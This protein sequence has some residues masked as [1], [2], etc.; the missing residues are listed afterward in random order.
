MANKKSDWGSCVCTRLQKKNG[1]WVAVARYRTKMPKTAKARRESIFFK[2]GPV[3][4][5]YGDGHVMINTSETMKFV[6]C[7]TWN[8][9]KK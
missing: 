1:R 9:P 2:N 4:K 3:T 8:I 5:T 7:P 6:Y